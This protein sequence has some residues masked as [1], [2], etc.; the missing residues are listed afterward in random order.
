LIS[1]GDLVF[2][3]RKERKSPWEEGGDMGDA[4]K[5]RERVNCNFNQNIM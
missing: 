5:K 3:D 4:G 2:S 1:R